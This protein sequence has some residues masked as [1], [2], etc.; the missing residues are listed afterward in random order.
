MKR[1]CSCFFMDGDPV[2][3]SEKEYVS[4][5]Y[6]EELMYISMLHDMEN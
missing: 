1:F 2:A 3:S 4:R 5:M 6:R